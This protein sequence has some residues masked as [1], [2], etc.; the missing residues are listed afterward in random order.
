[1]NYKIFLRTK[2]VAKNGFSPVCL[3]TNFDRTLPV[4]VKECDWS[5]T[6]LEVKRLW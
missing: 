1:M 3:R 2:A 6:K 4:N 5:E